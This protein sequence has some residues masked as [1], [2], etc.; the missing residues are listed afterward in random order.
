MHMITHFSSGDELGQLLGELVTELE[1][2]VLTIQQGINVFSAVLEGGTADVL[3]ALLT[4]F[5]LRL[6]AAGP[7]YIQLQME[8][9]LA[10]Y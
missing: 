4:D 6:A 10:G 2:S 7:Q 1:S 9:M 5:T 3:L 8:W